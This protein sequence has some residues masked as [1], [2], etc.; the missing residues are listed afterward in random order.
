MD[1]VAATHPAGEAV[2]SYASKLRTRKQITTRVHGQLKVH[3]PACSTFGLRASGS[4]TPGLLVH[5]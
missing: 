4:G 1:V 5:R 3:A 2:R